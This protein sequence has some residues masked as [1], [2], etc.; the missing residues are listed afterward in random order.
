[1]EE[2][3]GQKREGVEAMGSKWKLR[4]LCFIHPVD[5]STMDSSPLCFLSKN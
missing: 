1:M 3:A 5:G 4:V 2:S